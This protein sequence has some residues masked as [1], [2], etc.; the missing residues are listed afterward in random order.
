MLHL[1]KNGE[2]RKKVCLFA[3]AVNLRKDSWNRYWEDAEQLLAIFPLSP[4]TV[5]EVF[6][7]VNSSQFPHG[8]CHR[9]A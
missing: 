5:P 7:E 3:G 4:V 2:L 1:Q 6:A 9:S 8:E